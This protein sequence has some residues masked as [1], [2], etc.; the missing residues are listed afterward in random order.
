MTISGHL[1]NP[2]EGDHKTQM[3]AEAGGAATGLGLDDSRVSPDGRRFLMVKEAGADQGDQLVKDVRQRI[4]NCS[5]S[6]M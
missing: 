1:V 4:R 5:A 3:R 2:L 6:A